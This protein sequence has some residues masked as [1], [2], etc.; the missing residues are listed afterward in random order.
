[1]TPMFYI[2]GSLP[3]INQQNPPRK[4]LEYALPR[5]PPNIR[6]KITSFH[7]TNRKW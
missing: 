6:N 2:T 1:M 4:T 5:Y 7:S 3:R